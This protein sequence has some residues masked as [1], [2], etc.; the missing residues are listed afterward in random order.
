MTKPTIQT[1]RN[2]RTDFSYIERFKQRAKDG[3]LEDAPVPADDVDLEFIYRANNGVTFIASRKGGVYSYCE[4]VDD[5]RIR[6]YIPL[7][8]IYLGEGHLCRELRLHTPGAFYNGEIENIAEPEHTGIFLWKGKSDD[9]ELTAELEAILPRLIKG[10]DALYIHLDLDQESLKLTIREDGETLGEISRALIEDPKTPIY[11]GIPNI[12]VDDTFQ[13]HYYVPGLAAITHD[14]YETNCFINFS[15]DL[16]NDQ[17][18]GSGF[19]ARGMITLYYDGDREATF[20]IEYFPEWTYVFPKDENATSGDADSV[21]YGDIYSF[22]KDRPVSG[23]SVWEAFVGRVVYR[24]ATTIMFGQYLVRCSIDTNFDDA[25]VMTGFYADKTGANKKVT[26]TFSKNAEWSIDSDASDIIRAHYT[27]ETLAA[28]STN[29]PVTISLL[30]YREGSTYSKTENSVP[31]VEIA[32]ILA[33]D[34]PAK[35]TVRLMRR[36]SGK[37]NFNGWRNPMDGTEAGFS[38]SQGAWGAIGSANITL[39]KPQ[40]IC[41][42]FQLT[43]RAGGTLKYGGLSSRD[44]TL[45]DMLVWQLGIKN[46][47]PSNPLNWAVRATFGGNFVRNKGTQLTQSGEVGFG[48]RFT[49]LGLAVYKDNKRVSEICEF[50][51]FL[52]IRIAFNG[53][54]AAPGYTVTKALANFIDTNI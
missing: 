20:E 18:M 3:T 24:A 25:L 40:K 47:E 29:Y 48:F 45:A 17:Y 16:F 5:T 11:I 51:A 26:V 28:G 49:R 19:K 41:S 4:K 50:S 13:G 32:G 8:Q 2:F 9:A 35:Y 6:V 22:S 21:N 43:D 34:D 37:H 36:A 23:E 39:G 33:G 53:N 52:S 44:V 12:F 27:V 7:S 1:R 14:D 10:T 15:G 31:R 42:V 30:N 38:G 46:M 54:T